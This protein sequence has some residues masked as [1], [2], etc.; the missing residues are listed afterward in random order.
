MKLPVLY[1]KGPR[2]EFTRIMMLLCLRGF[3]FLFANSADPNDMPH[4]A[5]CDISSCQNTF[6]EESS[7]KRDNERSY[8][9]RRIHKHK[10]IHV[11]SKEVDI[12]NSIRVCVCVRCARARA[13][14]CVCVCGWVRLRTPL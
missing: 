4:V 11:T 6:L 7:I 13:C 3:V 9:Y 12:K 1:F 8:T 5:C 14:V 10:H 2:V